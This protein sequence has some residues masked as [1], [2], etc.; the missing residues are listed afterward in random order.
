MSSAAE[1]SSSCCW[2]LTSKSQLTVKFD[3]KN[4]ETVGGRIT[5][6]NLFSE[7]RSHKHLWRCLQRYLHCRT[8]SRVALNPS[9]PISAPAIVTLYI[10]THQRPDFC[11]KIWCNKLRRIIIQIMACLQFLSF[12]ANPNQGHVA[13]M[14]HR[15]I[16]LSTGHTSD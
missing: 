6:M 7:P 8:T 5:T 2:S 4:R 14:S 1:N 16:Q 11:M 13:V 9:A 12:H 15:S 10:P 3:I